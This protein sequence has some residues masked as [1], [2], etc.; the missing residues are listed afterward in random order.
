[1]ARKHIRAPPHWNTVPTESHSDGQLAGYLSRTLRTL[2][3]SLGYGEPLLFIRTP[4]LLHGNTYLW[5]ERV[6]IY[7]KS[8]TDRVRRIH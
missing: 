1:M 5:H 8:T 2:L 4:R 6:V 3:R 7:E